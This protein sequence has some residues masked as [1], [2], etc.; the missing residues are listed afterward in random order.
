[1][2]NIIFLSTLIFSSVS[3]AA[4]EV[5]FTSPLPAGETEIGS[6]SYNSLT[7]STSDIIHGLKNKAE[8]M[9]GNYFKITSFEVTH[10]SRGTAIVYK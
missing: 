10:N 2:K 4:T 5:T 8:K 1:M 3:M 7:G 6:V 9:G